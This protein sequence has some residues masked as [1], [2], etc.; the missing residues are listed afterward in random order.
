M[1]QKKGYRTERDSLG[2]MSVPE[3]A[4][5]GPQTQRAVENF[6]ISGFRFPRGFIHALGLVKYAAGRA[7]LKLGLLE[8]E[9]GEAICRAAQEV[10][11]GKWDDQ[12][13]V[14]IFQTG[15]GTSTNM[16]ANEVIGNRANLLLGGSIGSKVPVHPNDH[17][18]MGQSSNDVIPTC[19]HLAAVEAVKKRLVPALLRLQQQLDEKAA[20]FDAIIKLGRTHLQDA[21][22]VRLG[23][24]FGGYSRMVALSIQRLE[25]N[26]D[27]LHELALGG[28]AVGTGINAHPDHA[29][30]AIAEINRLT[31]G[32]F[33]EAANHFEA[34][35]AKDAVVELSGT[36][37][38]LAA[39]LTKIA[40][41]IRWMGA[42]PYGSLGELQLPA[43]QPGSSIMPGKINPVMA[44][45]LCQVAAQ[46]IGNDAA[47]TISG[48]SGNF[49]LNVMM[50]V[51][52]HNLLSSLELLTNAVDVFTT[53]CVAGLIANEVRCRE[54]VEK[55]LAMVTALNPY[56]GYDKAAEIAK[57]AYHTGKS[58][59]E[60][61]LEK[62]IMLAEKLD[63]VLDPYTMTVRQGGSF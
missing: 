18:N 63:E 35:G 2:E 33:R 5:W 13:V 1:N 49:E 28:T 61:I 8:Q 60:V 20:A 29:G 31:G 48:L 15:S 32:E 55:S 12:F 40:N 16:N 43:V 22:P 19:L 11:D 54:L 30:L 46:V 39:S 52:A 26:L 57:E 21:T 27:H 9:P 47:I 36:L 41:D 7:N 10:I 34:Q 25:K 58:L 50:P 17:V 56:I 45:A 59:R 37:K 24:E 3:D 38:T 44:E 51:M 6:L 4:L 53:K 42:G 62:K 23:Q 14:D